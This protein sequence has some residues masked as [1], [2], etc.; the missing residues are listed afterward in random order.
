MT[1][2]TL[3]IDGKTIQI[4]KLTIQQIIELSSETFEVNRHALL[5]DLED[6]GASPADRAKALADYRRE[7]D[8]NSVLIRSAFT[9][10]GSYAIVNKACNGMPDELN[11]LDPAEFTNI[12][13]SCLGMEV[14]GEGT[15]AEGKAEEAG[16]T[17]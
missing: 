15:S 6:A 7:Q 11:S 12:A 10:A 1:P 9:A 5:K 16:E 14:K 2:K 3:I 8:L 13:L 4:P 17:G